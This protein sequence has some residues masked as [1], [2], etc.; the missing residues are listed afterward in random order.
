MEKCRTLKSKRWKPPPAPPPTP[1]PGGRTRL[2]QKLIRQ[3][4]QKGRVYRR[5]WF[6][7]DWTKPAASAS[8]VTWLMQRQRNVYESPC[9][10]SLTRVVRKSSCVGVS[11]AR[12]LLTVKPFA[13]LL[14]RF[15][16][17]YLSFSKYIF[18]SSLLAISVLK[19]S[20]CASAQ[21]FLQFSKHIEEKPD[22]TNLITRFCRFMKSRM[23]ECW[24]KVKLECC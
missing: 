20:G 1:M 5:G 14:P 6:N 23:F 9:K 18:N 13:K 11:C 17:S 15:M 22:T 2:W 24:G 21:D 19:S 7:P 16:F 3:V 10:Q 4:L 12:C 8:H